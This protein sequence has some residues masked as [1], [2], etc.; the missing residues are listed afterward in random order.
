[1]HGYAEQ[2]Q[3]PSR[4]PELSTADGDL[5]RVALRAGW[6]P[7]ASEFQRTVTARASSMNWWDWISVVGAILTFLGV[8]VAGQGIRLTYAQAKE[9]V[10]AAEATQKAVARVTKHLASNQLLLLLPQLLQ[11]Q[12]QLDGTT[13]G[14][15]DVEARALL[16]RWHHLASESIGLLTGMGWEDQDFLDRVKKSVALASKAKRVLLRGN[17]TVIE[18]TE[19]VRAAMEDVCGEISTLAGQ[20]RAEAGGKQ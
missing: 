6:F 3:V 15:Q 16:V 20:F 18:A 5:Q 14:N 11:I 4:A 10:T 13:V 9:A 8:V 17:K 7:L 1:M 12:E 2:W 19:Q